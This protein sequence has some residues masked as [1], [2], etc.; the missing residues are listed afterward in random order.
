M[1]SNPQIFCGQFHK[2]LKMHLIEQF[3]QPWQAAI[4]TS[5]RFVTRRFCHLI[6][7]VFIC[8]CFVCCFVCLWNWSAVLLC[9]WKSRILKSWIYNDTMTWKHFPHHPPFV[10]RIHQS[11]EDTPKKR[12]ASGALG[13][14]WCQAAQAHEQGVVSSV[15]WDMMV[16][17]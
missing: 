14:L 15:L 5:S 9:Q 4:S 17:I 2:V 1:W 6:C 10:E 7:F 8:F 12:T 11:S 13:F 3:I 16:L